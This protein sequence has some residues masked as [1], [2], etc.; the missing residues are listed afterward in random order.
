MLAKVEMELDLDLDRQPLLRLSTASTSTHPLVRETVG[1][2]G[3]DENRGRLFLPILA[4]LMFFMQGQTPMRPLFAR[5]SRGTARE[6]YINTAETG[7]MLSLQ[8]TPLG[9]LT[10]E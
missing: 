9:R 3:S 7:R 5:Y 2:P 10:V 8:G 1:G 6:N 4:W